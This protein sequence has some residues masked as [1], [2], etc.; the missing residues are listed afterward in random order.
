[1]PSDPAFVSLL[2]ANKL[3]I[4]VLADA[5]FEDAESIRKL[6]AAGKLADAGVIL[7]SEVV[8]RDEANV[9]D[10]F[11]Q[12][13]YLK[14][15]NGAYKAHLNGLD[16]KVGDLSK[17]DRIT[18]RGEAVMRERGPAGEGLRSP[19]PGGAHAVTDLFAGRLGGTP[20]PAVPDLEVLDT[21]EL[22][23]R[24]LSPTA[25]SIRGQ[26]HP[27][28]GPADVPRSGHRCDRATGPGGNHNSP[29]QRGPGNPPI[30]G[31]QTESPCV[32]TFPGTRILKL[33]INFLAAAG[34]A[35]QCRTRRLQSRSARCPYPRP[36]FHTNRPSGALALER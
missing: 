11:D 3:N 28:S 10:L 34:G 17:G 30:A 36:G 33:L 31:L 1:V 12:A 18:K 25:P 7:I 32:G 29:N 23:L 4:A 2:G 19:G 9:E 35:A 21:V 14:L 15:V 27:R 5:G 22:L 6:E 16:I 13:F 26:S 24:T 20:V 8:G